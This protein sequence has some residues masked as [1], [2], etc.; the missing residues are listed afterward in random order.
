MKEFE[1]K[2]IKKGKEIVVLL[3]NV[4]ND[5]SPQPLSAREL[6]TTIESMYNTDRRYSK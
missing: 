4:M 6:H 1:V 2:F 3:V 5:K